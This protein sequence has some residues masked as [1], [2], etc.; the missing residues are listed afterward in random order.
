MRKSR[1]LLLTSLPVNARQ[2][3][4]AYADFD[5]GDNEYLEAT[6]LSF[7]LDSTARNALNSNSLIQLRSNLAST[8]FERFPDGSLQA[9][10]LFAIMY[11]QGGFAHH[12]D[13]AGVFKSPLAQRHLDRI[14]LRVCDSQGNAVATAGTF[15]CVI[16]IDLVS[17]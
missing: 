6:L 2:T 9:T 17:V 13:G 16:R 10:D 3:V 7:E 11:N 8:S 15:S 12:D 1:T 4:H 5:A 14:D